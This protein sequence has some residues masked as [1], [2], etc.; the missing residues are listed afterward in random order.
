MLYLGLILSFSVF[1]AYSSAG[2][3]LSVAFGR[4]LGYDG[5]FEPLHQGGPFAGHAGDKGILFG[6]GAH[7]ECIY[8]ILVYFTANLR[9]FLVNA[10]PGSV[11]WC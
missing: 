11:K 4:A 9:F 7:V 2:S 3:Y 6:A 5:V 8:F 10:K 1:F